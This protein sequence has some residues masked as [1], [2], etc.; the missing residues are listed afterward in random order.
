MGTTTLAEMMMMMK[1][2]SLASNIWRKNRCHLTA[3]L[4]SS[5]T[6]AI[7]GTWLGCLWVVPNSGGTRTENSIFGYQ[8]SAKNGFKA[9]WTSLLFIGPDPLNLRNGTNT[10][11]NFHYQI[12]ALDLGGDMRTKILRWISVQNLRPKNQYWEY[13]KPG[14]WVPILPLSA[15]VVALLWKIGLLHIVQCLHFSPFTIG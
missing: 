14:F 8:E 2:K 13:P 15:E 1:R 5:A 10:D 4:T 12:L 11:Q 3:G 9:S 6:R 7:F